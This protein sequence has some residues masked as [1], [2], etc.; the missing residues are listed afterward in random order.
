MAK[1]FRRGVGSV[2]FKGLG[3]RES[4]FGGFASGFNDE[5]LGFSASGS[6][7]YRAWS[8]EASEAGRK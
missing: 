4:G 1:K 6:E 7:G 5:G 2:G 3:L 8:F